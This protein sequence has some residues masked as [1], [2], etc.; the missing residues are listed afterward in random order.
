VS[1]CQRFYDRCF[2][3]KL[4]RSREHAACSGLKCT[5]K[6]S[7]GWAV[8][9]VPAASKFIPHRQTTILIP[10]GTT[11]HLVRP[12]NVIMEWVAIFTRSVLIA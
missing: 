2:P 11:P 8:A 6:N 12:G 10:S 1:M 9:R 4:C 3:S 7:K 5:C